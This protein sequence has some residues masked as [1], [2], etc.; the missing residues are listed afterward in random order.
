M[1]LKHNFLNPA[2]NYQIDYLSAQQVMLN[3]WIVLYCIVLWG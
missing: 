1:Y 2:L 3:F